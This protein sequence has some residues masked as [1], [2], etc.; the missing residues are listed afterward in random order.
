MDVVRVF[1]ARVVDL[2]P[3]S[4][5]IEITGAEE[6]INALVEVLRP[7]GIL[8][9]VRTGQVVMTRGL[10]QHYAAVRSGVSEQPDRK[11][12]SPT[13]SGSNDA[14]SVEIAEAPHSV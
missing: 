3:T 6:K 9:M 8:E 11:T 4:V 5:V 12:D 2:D 10:Q 14:K 13:R 7:F 1:R